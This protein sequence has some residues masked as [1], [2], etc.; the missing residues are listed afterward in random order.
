[1]SVDDT[2]NW[3]S[4]PVT[5]LFSL[6]ARVPISS[7]D[8]LFDALKKFATENGFGFD[9]RW[10]MREE[11]TMSVHMVRSDVS[12]FAGNGFDPEEFHINLL[13]ERN[14]SVSG[15]V[16]KELESKLLDCLKSVPGVTVKNR[17][18]VSH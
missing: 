17:P 5:P 10:L 18:V 15:E 4:R 7:R 1:M 3:R 2:A 11:N 9:V 16:A 6:I 13:E 8:L 14:N 12:L